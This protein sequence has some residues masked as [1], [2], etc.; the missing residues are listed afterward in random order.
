[1]NSPFRA[2]TSVWSHISVGWN[3]S[4]AH[5]SVNS[6]L[7]GTTELYSVLLEDSG[8]VGEGSSSQ[9]LGV[10]VEPRGKEGVMLIGAWRGAPD[11][12]GTDARG[13]YYNGQLD[14][15]EVRLYP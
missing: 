14:N 6:S 3:A 12:T 7:C 4:H 2:K 5:A 1:M 10:S 13:G 9:G 11:G 8:G 15:L